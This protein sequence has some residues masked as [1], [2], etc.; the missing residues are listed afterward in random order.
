LVVLTAETNCCSCRQVFEVDSARDAAHSGTA[1][2]CRSHD[3]DAAV[4]GNH[5]LFA[6]ERLLSL[7]LTK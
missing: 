2:V 1:Q 5:R 6:A 7:Q 3:A 4:A